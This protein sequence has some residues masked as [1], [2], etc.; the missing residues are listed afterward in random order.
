MESK[1]QLLAKKCVNKFKTMH[2]QHDTIIALF[3]N[4]VNDLDN[5][6]FSFLKLDQHLHPIANQW[7]MMTIGLLM[8]DYTQIWDKMLDFSP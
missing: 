3:I 1:K 5:V 6:Q 7:L 4:F 2:V 8:V